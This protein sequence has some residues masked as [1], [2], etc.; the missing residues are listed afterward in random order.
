MKT[1]RT[2][3]QRCP[4][5]LPRIGPMRELES[6]FNNLQLGC[7]PL[8]L[9]ERPANRSISDATWLLINQCAYLH[10][11]GKLPQRQAQCLGRQIKAALGGD[12]RQHTANVACKVEGY[13]S[14]KQPKEV[15]RCLKGWYHSATNQPP[16]PCH[17][18]MTRLTEEWTA[19]YTRVPTPGGRFSIVVDP[20]LVWDELPTDSKI[21]DG[22]QTLW[23]GRAAGAGGMHAEHLKEWLL[24]VV[25]EKKKGTEGAGD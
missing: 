23:N 11:S 19:L 12:W 17:L 24:G 14:T 15:W 8:P 3:C 1:Y 18:P 4:L 22:V 7:K 9:R 2:A 25:E 16:K 20:F 6:L 5:R 13:L 21:R 10:K